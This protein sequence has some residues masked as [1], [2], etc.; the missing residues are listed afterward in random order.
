MVKSKVRQ[1]EFTLGPKARSLLDGQLDDTIVSCVGTLGLNEQ[2]W[3][4]GMS[5][6]NNSGLSIVFYHSFTLG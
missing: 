6:N 3:K 4:K 1:T 2:K 5:E